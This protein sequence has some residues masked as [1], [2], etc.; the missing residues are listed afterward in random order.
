MRRFLVIK[1]AGI[2]GVAG[3][4]ACLIA[5][6]PAANTDEGQ[7][8]FKTQCSICHAS[9]AGKTGLGPSLAGVTGRKAGT[10]AG[11]AYS[12]AMKARASK[13]DKATLDKFLTD[14]RT[15]I[16][17]NRMI[18]AGQKDAAKRAAL[19]AYLATLK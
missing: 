19:V 17:G 12:P 1:S 16:P 15:A 13:W 3:L 8:L 2:L 4:A 14:P 18:F 11:F 6:A 10:L 9:V 5:A 7:A